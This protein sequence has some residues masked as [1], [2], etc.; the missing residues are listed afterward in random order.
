MDWKML[1]CPNKSCKYY[2]MP[3]QSGKMVKNGTC[4]GQPQA[5]CKGC[6]SSVVLNYATAYYGLE[7]DAVI[8]ETAV[9]ALA[10]GNSIRAAGRIFEID[11]D[12]VCDWLIRASLHCRSVVLYFWNQLHVAECQLDELW[13]FVLARQTDGMLLNQEKFRL[14]GICRDSVHGSHRFH[15][16]MPKKP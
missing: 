10:E 9:R 1:Y 16:I 14:F 11:K 2:G 7:S 13:S 3:F 12:T 6:G 5:L 15:G 8:F 4:H